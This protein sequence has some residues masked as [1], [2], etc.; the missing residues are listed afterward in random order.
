MKKLIYL[1]PVLLLLVGFTLRP[2]S[3]P[4]AMFPKNID[5]KMMVNSDGSNYVAPKVVEEEAKNP[6]LPMP[7]LP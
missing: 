6:S 1:V 5:E 2:S 7:L 4:I 3:S